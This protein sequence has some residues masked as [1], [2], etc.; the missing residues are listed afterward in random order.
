MTDKGKAAWFLALFSPMVAEMLSGSSPPLEFFTPFGLLVLIPMYGGGALLVR[1]LAIRW[2]KGW[3]TIIVL[4]AAYGII[5]EG[6]AVK[7]F[8]DPGW[9]DLGE[10]GEYGRALGVNWV[11]SVWLTIYHSMISISLPILVLG[12]WYPH[13]KGQSVLTKRQFGFVGWLFLMDIAFCAVLFVF[14]QDFVPPPVQYGCCF[15]AVYLL[16]SLAKRLPKDAMSARHSLPSWRPAKFMALGFVTLTFSF[17][18]ASSAPAAL[19]FP[20]T[21]LLLIAVSGGAILV[22]Q[23]R[24]GSSRNSVHLA[25]FAVGLILLFIVLGPVQEFSNGMA[26]MTLVSAGFAVFSALLIRRAKDGAREGP[27]L[28]QT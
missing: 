22:L 4:G 3:A 2:G 25:C 10:L 15:L 23:H 13:L 19:P 11:W 7:S 20:L 5:E 9:V 1:E 24:I 8:M 12:L 28:Q 16:Y 21:I 6:I 17:L 14:A 18:F 27:G 26:G